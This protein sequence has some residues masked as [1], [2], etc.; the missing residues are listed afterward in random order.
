MLAAGYEP[1]AMPSLAGEAGKRWFCRWR[2]EFGIASR[3]TGQPLTVSRKKVSRY[4][5]PFWFSNMLA[6][7]KP[8]LVARSH[9]PKNNESKVSNECDEKK[10]KE[11][12]QDL[13]FHWYM[14][15]SGQTKKL[16]V[17]PKQVENSTTLNPHSLSSHNGRLDYFRCQSE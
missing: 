5:Q 10:D 11:M 14:D 16:M 17:F 8:V 9:M 3:R 12:V 6:D 4:Q 1:Q 13:E 2:M 7:M 15:Y